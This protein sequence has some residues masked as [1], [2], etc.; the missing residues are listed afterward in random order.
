MTYRETTPVSSA[1]TLSMAGKT[2]LVTGGARG[3]GAA[4][5]RLIIALGGEV[6]VA[7]ILQEEGADLVSDLGPRARFVPLD[8]TRS[9]DWA[10]CVTMA[11]SAFG[12]LNVLVNNAGIVS[13]GSISDFD[14]DQWR[15]ILDVNLTG[16]YLGIRAARDALVAAAPASIVNVSSTAGLQGQARFHGYCAS[17]F[18]LRGLTKS[19][20][21]ELGPHGVRCNSV[22]PG[23]VQTPL[24]SG[25]DLSNAFGVLGRAAEPEELA[26]LIVYLASDQSS[27]STGSEFVAD[28]GL[29]AGR[30]APRPVD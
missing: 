23:A 4:T 18:G 17:K 12:R 24:T 2:A 10:A 7:D 9:Q 25:L 29:M 3:I 15:K 20:A 26:Q 19:V 22:H 5:A 8:V 28:G 27:F 16:P 21:M 6:V 13:V 14:E 30:G 1:N 11:Q